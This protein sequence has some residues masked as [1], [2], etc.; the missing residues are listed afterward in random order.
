MAQGRRP[1]PKAR[2]AKQVGAVQ[3]L[4]T[5]SS[6]F[7]DREALRRLIREIVR[8]ILQR[9]ENEVSV[10]P[11]VLSD[12]GFLLLRIDGRVYSIGQAELQQFH[13][14]HLE[15]DPRVIQFLDDNPGARNVQNAMRVVQ[16]AMSEG[17]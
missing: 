2:R 15:T 1:K 3:T 6:N 11:Y 17:G 10:P 5:R 16:I 13:R 7:L 8:E 9:P 14:A 4:S 12:H